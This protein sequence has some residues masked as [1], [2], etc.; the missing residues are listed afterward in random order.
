MNYLKHSNAI[1]H[2]ERRTTLADKALYLVGAIGIIVALLACY[3]T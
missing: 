3:F 2:Y 1:E